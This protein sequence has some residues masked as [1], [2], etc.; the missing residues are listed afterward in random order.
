MVDNYRADAARAL[1][2]LAAGVVRTAEAEVTVDRLAVAAGKA[3]VVRPLVA[4]TAEADMH[5]Q[6]S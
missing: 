5:N 1:D 4:R 3:V 6:L 2:L